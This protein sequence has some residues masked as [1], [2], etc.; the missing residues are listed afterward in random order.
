MLKADIIGQVRCLA[1]KSAILEVGGWMAG[2][3]ELAGCAA[4]WVGGVA[5]ICDVRGRE[6]LWPA[7]GASAHEEELTRGFLKRTRINLS[8]R[9]V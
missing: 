5:A 2:R 1:R 8:M 4:G 7:H 6:E 9:R 3:L